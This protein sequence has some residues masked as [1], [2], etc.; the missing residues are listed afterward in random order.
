MATAEERGGYG[1][2]YDQ[3]RDASM[4]QARQDNLA[5][6]AQPGLGVGSYLPEAYYPHKKPWY[7]NPAWSP[8]QAAAPAPAPAPAPTPAPASAGT[9]LITPDG[10]V[11]GTLEVNAQGQT[12]VRKLPKGRPNRWNV[13]A[14][15]AA[16]YPTP[17]GFEAAAQGAPGL[18]DLASMMDQIRAGFGGPGKQR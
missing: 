14:D 6:V 8:G 12:V 9:P 1:T 2:T 17:P 15:R 18:P 13:P 16:R 5:Y 3:R 4:Q 11:Y 10:Q 7:E